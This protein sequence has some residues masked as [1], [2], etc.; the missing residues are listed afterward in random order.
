MDAM[1]PLTPFCLEKSTSEIQDIFKAESKYNINSN[2]GNNFIITIKNLTSFIEINADYQNNKELNHF[3]KKYSLKNLKEIKF[4]SICDSI[5]EIYDELLFEFSKNNSTIIEDI[6]QIIINIPITHVKY[7]EISFNLNKREKTEKEMIQDLYKL[8]YDLKE[9]IKN[10]D[11]ENKEKINLCNNEI[12]D[13]RQ[14]IKCL[15]ENNKILIKKIENLEKEISEL[16]NDKKLLNEQIQ[17]LKNKNNITH[18]KTNVISEKEFEIIE[19]PWTKELYKECK[20]FEFTLKDKDYF[21]ER[22]KGFI[23]R[24][25]KSKHKFE[26]NKIYKLIYNINYLN[27]DFRIG[28]GDFGKCSSRLK[29]KGSVGLTNEGLFIDGIMESNIELKKSNKEITFIINLKEK[30]KNFELFIDGKSYGKFIFNLDIIYGIAA[31]QDGSIKI[32]T[33]RSLN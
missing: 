24:T 2:K 7:K 22:S 29:E 5:D 27:C 8:I 18:Q 1:E 15:D 11:K 6:N 23:V 19:N 4:L 9:E 31:F 16:K 28:F 13:L 14:I 20:I 17:Y 33:Y 26:S 21:A 30:E 12:N 3:N 10:K 25:I 32:N